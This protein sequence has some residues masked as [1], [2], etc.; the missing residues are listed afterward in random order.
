MRKAVKIHKEDIEDVIALTPVQEGILYH[1]LKE[2]EG[3]LYHEEL[4][5]CLTGKIN[6]PKFEEAWN[7]VTR[8]NE[9]L[10]TIFRWEKVKQ[11]VQLILKE[12]TPNIIYSDGKVSN[13]TESF[14]LQ[15]V[16]FS[17]E[18]CH[19]NEG[20]Y[21]MV[22]RHHHILFDGWSNSI[23]LQEFIKVY[24]ELIKGDV[25]S[26][27]N[28]K[29]FKEYILWQQKQDKLKQ[30]LFWEQYLNELTEQ[31]NLSNKNSNQLKKAKTYVK[32]IDKEQ[33]D[34]FRSFAS[35]QG[36]TLATLFYTAWGLL[37]QRYKNSEDVI[38]GTTVSGR[39]IPMHGLSE[40]VGL[41]INTPPLRVSADGRM[42]VSDLLQRIQS[43]VQR[44]TE[45]ETTPIVDLNVSFDTIM[46]VENYPLD[47]EQL[48]EIDESVRIS[49][50]EVNEMT[51]YDLT[52]SIECFDSIKLAMMWPED[53]FDESIITSITNHFIQLLDSMLLDEGQPIQTLKM[54]DEAEEKFLLQGGQ[55]QSA[56]FPHTTLHQLIEMQAEKHPERVALTFENSEMT[57]GELNERAD[58]VAFALLKEGVTLDSPVAVMLDYSFNMI[59]SLLGILKA[60]GAYVPIDPDYPQERID[61]ILQDSGSN[62]IITSNL[63]EDK[64]KFDSTL[65]F[66]EELNKTPMQDFQRVDVAPNNLAYVIYTSGT[67]GRP[68]GVMIE[69]SN[70]IQLV[71]HQPNSFKF[72]SNDVWL[73]F[74]SFCFDMSVWEIFGSLTYGGRLVLATKETIRDTYK[75]AQLIAD[76][77]VT[78]LNQTPSAFYV[79]QQV[80]EEMPKLAFKIRL[81]TFGG[82]MLKPGLLQ[83]WFKR[84]PNTV[85]VNMYGITETTV[86]VTYKE[87]GEKEMHS[88]LSAIGVPLPTYSCY[89]FDKHMNP[90]PKGMQGE[91][92]VGGYGVARGYLNRPELNSER[93]IQN[94]YNPSE[95]LY[96]SG[97]LVRILENGEME[98][99]GR[100]D[101]Q[102]K[103]RGYRIETGEIEHHLQQHADVKEAV[104][105][106]IAFGE[107]QELCAYILTDQ[108]ISQNELRYYL[109]DKIPSYMIPMYFVLLIEMPLT[110]NGKVNRRALP[111]PTK[112]VQPNDLLDELE[113]TVADVWKEVLGVEKVGLYDNFFDVGGNS[114]K[115]VRLFSRLRSKF[116]KELT[117]PML[118]RYP[119][120]HDQASYFRSDNAM[121]HQPEE[122]KKENFLSMNK[123]DV[124]VVGMAVRMP[125]ASN[126][127]QFWS[128]LEQ[129]I[130][131]IRTFTDEELSEMGIPKEV[132]QK[133]NYIK[134]K[135][136]L[137]DVDAFDN[138]FFDYS[139]KEAEMMDPQ[140]RILHEC[141]WEALEQAGE[142]NSS[143]MNT[144][145]YV[146]GSPN[147]HWLRSIASESSNTLEDFQAMLLNEKDFFATRLAY[148]LNLKGPAITVQTACSTS[149]VAIQNAW[150]DLIDGRCDIAL[151]GGVSITYPTKTGYLYED[152]M[153]F[154]PD[155]HC[156]AFDKD[157][158]GTVGG[159]GAGIVVLKRLE[160][161][162]RDGNLIHG[163]IKGAAVNNDGSNKAGFTAPG[164]DGQA[165]VIKSAHEIAGVK[166]EEISYIETH[167][168]GTQ[169][170]D[171]IEVE[172]LKLAFGKQEPGRVLIGS[173]K[174]NIGHLDAAAGV[175]G[176]IK[177]VLALKNKKIPPSLHYNNPN[178]NIDF[179]KNPFRVNTELIPWKEKVR[180]AGV[181]SFGMGG[182]NAHIVL[183]SVPDNAKNFE[184]QSWNLLAVSAKT[185]ES[186]DKATNDLLLHLKENPEITLSDTAYTLQKGR[187]EFPYRTAVVANGIEDAIEKLGDTGLEKTNAMESRPLA[188]LFSGQGSQYINMGRDLYENEPVFREHVDQ[189]LALL[190]NWLDIDMKNILY[191]TKETEDKATEQLNRT[192]M[193]QPLLFTIEYALAKLLMNW[194]VYPRVMF[195]H[196][197]GEFVAACLAEVMSYEDALHLVMIRG[198][199]MNSVPEGAMLSVNLSVEELKTYITDDVDIAAVNSSQHSVIS[200]TVLSINKIEGLLLNH[201]VKTTR[202]FTSHAF[203]SRMMDEVLDAFEQAVGNI[204]LSSPKIPYISNVTGEMITAN[205]ATS[206]SYWAQHLRST[207]QFSKGL[208]EIFH[209]KNVICLEIGP[210]NA[211]S[212][213][214]LK[215]L[216]RSKDQ[217][218]LNMLRHPLDK[219]N[220]FEH[221][222]KQMGRLWMQGGTIN[223]NTFNNSEN[224]RLLDLPTYPFMKKRFKTDPFFNTQS[225]SLTQ[226]TRGHNKQANIKDWFYL[227]SWERKTLKSI[228]IKKQQK[229]KWLIF[230]DH[231][232]RF[233][234]LIEKLKRG[235][236]DVIE[237]KTGGIF[238]E[239][240]DGLYT[241]CPSQKMHYE[242]LFSELEQKDLLPNKI[243][244]AWSFNPVNE[245]I[246]D[247]ERIE[248]S[249]D[250]GY[251]SLLY[252]AQAIGKINYEGALQLNIF[253]DRMFEVTGTELNLKPEQATI[254]GFSKICNLEFQN[255]KCRTID[256]DTDSQ[257]MFEE[258]G[259]MESFV[260]STDIVVAYRGRHRWAQTI[261]QSPFEE[262]DV[263]IDRLR[264][265]GVYLITGGLGGIGFEIAK[266]LANRVPNVKLILIGRS[267]FPPRNQWE[268]Y[269]ENK[270]ERVSRVIS[271]LL[272]MESQGAEYMILSSDVSN[273][274]DMKQAIDKAKSRFGSINGVI[275]AAGVADY[276]GIMMNREKESNNKILAPKI[277]GTLVL[278]A[279]LKDEPID[280][281]VLC[282]S[283]GNVAYHMKFGQSGYNAANEFLD[284][285]AFYKRAHDGVFTVAINWPDWQEVGMSLKSAE[286]WAKQFNMDME[287][288]LHDGVTV[289]EGLKVFRSIINRN[290][291]QVV[292]SP[293]D[294]HW[295]LLNGANYYNELLEKGSKNR[296]KQNRSDV[297][298]TYRP[299]TN[300]IEQQL[301]EL[302]KDMFGIEEIGIYDNFFD[303]GMSSLDLVRI[304]VKLKEAF[305]RDLPIVVLYEHTSIKSLAKYLSNQEVNN[306]LTNK[307]ELLK[308]KSVMKNTLSALK[309]RK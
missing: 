307:K 116:E 26:S 85:I 247:Q 238:S 80:V 79:F 159:N 277:K 9:M 44:R 149:L 111:K 19:L 18:L 161:A 47:I 239:K 106:S 212:T 289:E 303:L 71:M 220:D 174:T 130:E 219:S 105:L 234:R 217:L 293:I 97:D 134:S 33:S 235:G 237:V 51:N 192:S 57:Y 72:S 4:R 195:G 284:A 82:E 59:I 135:G 155:G 158:Q 27:I 187:R 24:R 240:S 108:D 177:T 163:V 12:H 10:R 206:P 166:P 2:P 218:A 213:F 122:V 260:D 146:G 64:V 180:R 182:T 73:L 32:E 78:L 244:H 157:A 225:Q 281:F 295:K 233:N 274:D 264:E 124:A 95:R 138:E 22:L 83:S 196:S 261:I 20:E 140:L 96:R 199:L 15:T 132:I 17:I 42:T 1:Y 183:E 294:L 272:T 50:Y 41:F 56:T 150:A 191:P 114:L 302:L 151:A 229:Y 21:E 66:I 141:A 125:G 308:A 189:G 162:L 291:Q 203:H 129:G 136:Y 258:A 265:G 297:S 255:I 121:E 11:P 123:N 286:I 232:N 231:L 98:Y 145:V 102:V 285:F 227:P 262:E 224:K 94:P 39:S 290:Q 252:I 190:S 269:L 210:G 68:K 88:N 109:T 104:V 279:L 36:V 37:L 226:E 87:I 167:G 103:I 110:T 120:V 282:S 89:V 175:G 100:S 305:K 40:M 299:P 271:D 34:R 133:P 62:V 230:N 245:V 25:P 306:N 69:H 119:T 304:N 246:L 267:E 77:G 118:F 16:P 48:K 6:I 117:M 222:C 107:E 49:G 99:I 259:L 223:W 112:L 74:H 91:L 7:Y 257:Q 184:K 181:S 147:F 165:A 278:D 296:L 127:K 273:Q 173:V 201:G 84:S 76:E 216:N 283:I 3:K 115:M 55:N 160:D 13:D 131:S 221:L 142:V 30:K 176:F 29:K 75:L 266:D 101:H 126:L 45:Y 171:P 54:L 86:H 276:L 292:V 8:E 153:I 137:E 179:G 14:D 63:F 256:M 139:L 202:L 28:K 81:L 241:I 204:K 309:S 5:L 211:L 156:R 188:F 288:V 280:F 185:E 214:V 298:T 250:E 168:T 148:K 208:S 154:S 209:L 205:Q 169:L 172:A 90:T 35:N 93:F 113:T 228:Q 243:I 200:G 70:V 253:T 300:E 268:Q 263:E 46:V 198:K 193:T 31:I 38:F 275:H 92:Y 67:T 128:N 249:M 58:K 43:D 207:V 23:I 52:V 60:G 251:Y 178:P 164:V 270:D 236:H 194:G 65:L 170:G 248:R 301:Y 144:G 53:L 242:M 186:L 61:F 215:H 197:I 152:G 143:H 254:L 287:S